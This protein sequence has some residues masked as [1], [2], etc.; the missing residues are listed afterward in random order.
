MI[1]PG[2]YPDIIVLSYEDREDV[3]P[4]WYA[5]VIKIFHVFVIHHRSAPQVEQTPIEPK[6]MDILWVHWFRLDSD[7]CGGWFKKCLYN[8]SFILCDEPAAL[9]FLD[10]AQVI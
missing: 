2:S 7:A 5:Q 10:P 9:G 8:I 3:H 4:F 1:S 6:H